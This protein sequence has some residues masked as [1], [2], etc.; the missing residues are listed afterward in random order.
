MGSIG[1]NNNGRLAPTRPSDA[2][3][4]ANARMLTA[5]LKPLFAWHDHFEL[6]RAAAERRQIPIG[7]VNTDKAAFAFVGLMENE[8]QAETGLVLPVKNRYQLWVQIT[9][10]QCAEEVMLTASRLAR[11]LGAPM[12]ARVHRGGYVPERAPG[13]GSGT[14]TEGAHV[15]PLGRHAWEL[16]QSRSHATADSLY[17]FEWPYVEGSDAALGIA[18]RAGAFTGVTRS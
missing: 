5:H 16:E 6:Q 15:I 4:A 10:H 12:S 3:I 7:W 2:T 18:T 1:D 14:A 11:E 8:G 9:A 17:C 13:A